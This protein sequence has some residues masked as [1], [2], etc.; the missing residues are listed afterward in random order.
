M[1]KMDKLDKNRNFKVVENINY[2]F[3]EKWCEKNNINLLVSQIL[4]DDLKNMLEKH[5]YQIL[6]E[7]SDINAIK[8]YQ[9]ETSKTVLG[10]KK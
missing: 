4:N 10:K 2:I 8:I 9:D 6:E 5:D 7:Y 1:D 3:R